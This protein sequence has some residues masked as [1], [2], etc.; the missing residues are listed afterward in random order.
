[1]QK[2][3][4]IRAVALA[5]F[6][7]VI[8]LPG[9]SW[10][11]SAVTLEAVRL[12]RPNA[13][14][15]AQGELEA[16]A[17]TNCPLW[18]RL[19]LLVGYLELSAGDAE[20][21]RVQLLSKPAPPELE[22]YRQY[23]LGEA[24]FYTRDPASAAKSFQSAFD[25][26]PASLTSRA[27]ARLGESLLASGDP[28]AAL[29]ALEKAA[30]DLDLPELY[31]E[32]SDARAA[33]GNPNGSL[34]DL[35]TLAVRFPSHPYGRKAYEELS[36][37]P[38]QPLTF[39]ERL[40]RAHALVDGNAQGALDEVEQIRTR[41][42][43][44]T[45]A[46][47]ARTA[48]VAASALFALGRDEDAAA[49]V[50]RAM[51]GPM[52]VAAEV[53]L[54]RA[55]RAL[56]KDDNAKARE[57]MA[58]V[59]KKFPKSRPAE[60]AGFFVGWL[61]FQAGNY[62][63]A[64]AAFTAYDKRHPRSRKRDEAYWFRALSLIRLQQYADAR[65]VLDTLV[66]KEPQSSLVPQALY[67]SARSRQLEGVD[68]AT[69]GPLY[70]Q[71]IS[72]FP[73]TFYA[74]LSELRLSELNQPAP[75]AFPDPPKRLDVSVPEPLQTAVAL[76]EAGLFKD[77]GTEV[78][79]QLSQVR[80]PELALT[81]GHALQR[82]GEF[83]QAH[84]LAARRLW[85]DAFTAKKGEALELFYPRA[86]DTSVLP[87]AQRF[88]VDPNLVWAI[89]RR[90]SVFVTDVRS[91]ANA[92]GLMQLVPQTGAAI[93]SEL[94]EHP[95]EPDDLFSPS[96]NIHLGTWYLAQLTKRFHHPALVAAA[97]NAG[98]KPAAKW[99]HDRG[100]L[101]LD[102]FVEMLPYRETRGYVKQVLADMHTY[103]LLYPEGHPALLELKVPTPD[104]TGVQF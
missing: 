39:D 54:M 42:L 32:R 11:Q 15:L 45:S 3:P 47:R 33:T 37:R 12:H 61:E 53:A 14:A 29:P 5:V 64:I 10:A 22:A 49:E 58:E 93:A 26:A 96:L 72:Q 8:C 48:Q 13:L 62:Q 70:G 74:W 50:E 60:E 56:K 6:T 95:P 102:L 89:M 76:A 68:P 1:M 84:Q 21:A 71:L 80:T 18:P 20:A 36:Q 44:R 4:W 103:H 75:A 63:P 27:R 91:G 101:P 67:W 104:E 35:K 28:A 92:R 87:E 24:Q 85:G 51:K 16:C 86:F 9:G 82:L 19:S 38:G 57:L 90:E 88:S 31:R 17:Q 52:D 69:L 83:G 94:N 66:K 46:Q 73:A 99:V 55:R 25:L 79:R 41:K 97:Y 78:Q 7:T 40:A 98:P 43:A 30:P 65:Q 100:D 2:H 81:Y 77:A 23:Y 59:D 34:A